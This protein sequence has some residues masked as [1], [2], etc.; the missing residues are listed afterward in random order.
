[1]TMPRAAVQYTISFFYA[2]FK[3]FLVSKLLNPCAYLI[4]KLAE[5]L[6][7]IP[8]ISLKPLGVLAYTSPRK[9]LTAR[10]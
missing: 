6:S 7:A 5:G 4:L 1:M 10:A 3:L 2:Y 8:G 9:G